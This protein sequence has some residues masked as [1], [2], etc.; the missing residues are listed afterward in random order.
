MRI[1]LSNDD[2]ILAPG[3]QRLAQELRLIAE[4]VFLIAPDRNRSGASSALTLDVPLRTYQYQNGDIAVQMG[5]PTDCVYL[6]VNRLMTPRPDMVISGINAGP[7]LGDDVIYSGTV[8][9][10]IEG[11]HL[12]LPAIA[13]SLNGQH[14]YATAAKVTRLLVE[15]LQRLPTRLSPVLNINVPDLPI[16]QI[17]GWKVTRCGYRHPSDNVI[18]QQ[19]PR[20]E[21]LYWIGP[22]GKPSDDGAGTDFEAIAQGYISITPLRVDLTAHD[23]VSELASWL[24][25]AEVK[26]SC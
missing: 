3:I 6:G 25:A 26:L 4:D 2:G 10:A 17:K 1:L 15:A 20:G 9:A 12:G 11:R 5:T 7:N 8:A 18:E 24:S 13:V 21:T 22:Q 23:A 16:E 19:D 14:H